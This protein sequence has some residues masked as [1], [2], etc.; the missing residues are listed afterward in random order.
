MKQ[1]ILIWQWLCY[2]KGTQKFSY[3]ADIQTVTF[4]PLQTDSMRFCCTM[5]AICSMGKCTQCL[6]VPVVGG[7][8]GVVCTSKW[9]RSLADYLALTC[10]NVIPIAS[11]EKSEFVG[12]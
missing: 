6:C 2:Q 10:T 5:L 12:S 11:E 9:E 1:A 4:F 3:V 7:H 8:P